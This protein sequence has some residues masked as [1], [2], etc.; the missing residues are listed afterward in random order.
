M[1]TEHLETSSC[2]KMTQVAVRLMGLLSMFCAV[3]V[4]AADLTFYVGTYTGGDSQGIYRLTM[5]PKSGELSDPVLVAETKNPSFLAIAASG[6]FVYAVS[7]VADA[8]GG[9]TGAIAAFS[10]EAES[11]QLKKLNERSSGGAGP[12]HLVVD[13]SG[14]FVLC[15]NYGGGSVAMLP[16]QPDGSLAE[17]ASIIQH[18]GSSVD[19]KR[20]EGPHA[21]SINVS[22]DGK[23]A[24]AADLGLDKLLVY[25]IDEAKPA[26]VPHD[27]PFAQTPPGGGPRHGAFHPSGRYF[28]CINEMHSSVTTCT[29]NATTG[30]LEPVHTES[31]L[32]KG[33]RKPNST[34]EVQAHP[35]GRFVYGSNRGDDSIAILHFDPSTKRLAWQKNVS[36]RGKTPRNFTIDPNGRF[37]VAANQGSSTL[38][39]FRIDEANGS[40]LSAGEPKAV[41]TPVCVKFVT[42]AK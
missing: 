34:A 8:L 32:P 14:R 28:F 41:P 33:S 25:R 11:G 24:V 40:L 12:C 15:A 6:K 5:H 27:P 4:Q 21:H 37:L 3:A 38:Q 18:E 31:T 16:I 1:P 39:V 9:K 10:V 2:R 22:A 35:N 36:T 19:P 29:F 23:F 20:Q 30:V 26:L 17:P 7:E 42:P 13:P